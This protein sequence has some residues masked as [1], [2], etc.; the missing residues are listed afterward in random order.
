VPP[1][2]KVF[3]VAACGTFF[4]EKRFG[5]AAPVPA[6]PLFGTGGGVTRTIPPAVD[7][8]AAVSC[9]MELG[10]SV[11]VVDVPGIADATITNNAGVTF[12]LESSMVELLVYR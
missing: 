2:V 4:K 11:P 9:G 1:L 10:E 6:G 8:L 3:T 7:S 5:I 12:M